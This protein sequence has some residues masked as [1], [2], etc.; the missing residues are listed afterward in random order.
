ML[1][2]S[3]HRKVLDIELTTAESELFVEHAKTGVSLAV[4]LVVAENA[5]NHRTEGAPL[6]DAASVQKGVGL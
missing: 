2:G 6:E 4:E 1:V 5:A 3:H